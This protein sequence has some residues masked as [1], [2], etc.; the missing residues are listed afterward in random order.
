MQRQQIQ[1][2]YAPWGHNCWANVYLPNDYNPAVKYPLLVSLHGQG[3]LGNTQSSLS[4]LE[5]A[6]GSIP[7]VISTGEFINPATGKEYEIIV[8]APQAP[9]SEG[10]S[11]QESEDSYLIPQLENLYSIDIT[12]I[13]ITG[14]SSGGN[15]TWTC[16]TDSLAFAQQ[17]IFI[18]PISA[19]PITSQEIV[20]LV[21]N[22]AATK[23]TIW[24]VCGTADSFYPANQQYFQQ[25][26]AANAVPP[27]SFFSI[28]GGGHWSTGAYST[29]FLGANG[30][31]MYDTFLG[32]KTAIPPLNLTIENTNALPGQLVT[33]TIENGSG[34][35][36]G[37]IQGT[38]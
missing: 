3:E 9:T 13:G 14:Y 11:F 19:A 32:I 2:A 31:N 8:F 12:Q 15:A 24:G 30:K 35:V 10:W 4:L 34:Q 37:T 36:I 22:Q 1:I 18:G 23:M 6:T 27:P 26:S 5:A 28:Q 21:P 7:N 38:I 25:L 33:V 17:L 16:L 29:K 20:T